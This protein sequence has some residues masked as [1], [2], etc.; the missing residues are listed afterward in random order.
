[1]GRPPEQNERGLRLDRRAGSVVEIRNRCLP[2]VV[3]RFGRE[4][5]QT[6]N[7]QN[8]PEERGRE[9]RLPKRA[10]Q[11]QE[12]GNPQD[13]D[14]QIQAVLD[15]ARRSNIGKPCNLHKFHP[16]EHAYDHENDHKDDAAHYP[17]QPT[18]PENTFLL[19]R[20]LYTIHHAY[21]SV[22]RY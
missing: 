19:R 2:D 8:T 1:M 13:Q 14:G 20:T 9:A 10:I 18:P 11:G 21:L 3:E 4:H 16:H 7:A 22:E 17:G 6:Q 5:H 12:V 15:Y